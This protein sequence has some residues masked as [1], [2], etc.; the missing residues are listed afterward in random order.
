M[1]MYYMYYAGCSLTTMN[2]PDDLAR[3]RALVCHWVAV[4]RCGNI[5]WDSMSLLPVD[6]RD[7]GA[8]CDARTIPKQH[9]ET[10]DGPVRGEEV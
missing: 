3:S 9:D 4:R 10:E 5:Q 2:G 7:G 8:A 1:Y 6:C